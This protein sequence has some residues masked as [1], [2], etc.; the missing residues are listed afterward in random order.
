MLASQVE[1]GPR[2]RGRVQMVEARKG[3]D[4]NSPL[5]LP[6]KT[7]ILAQ[8][9]PGQ[10]AD[11]Q[12]WKIIHL[13]LFKTLNLW[14]CVTAAENKPTSHPNSLCVSQGQAQ[15]CSMWGRQ[16]GSLAIVHEVACPVPQSVRATCCSLTI[17]A[18]H[19][20]QCWRLLPGESLCLLFSQSFQAYKAPQQLV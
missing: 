5:E 12:H 2:A 10:T 17:P 19:L 20:G 13:C 3:K 8:R 1:E 18:S 15:R 6:D 7:L 11:L 14:Q 4:M 9:D 16:P